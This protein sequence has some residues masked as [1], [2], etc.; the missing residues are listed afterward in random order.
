MLHRDYL[1]EQFVRF[2]EAIRLSWR[3]SKG[4]DADPLAAAELLE[5]A[6]GTATSI[7]GATLLML[8]PDSIAS[9]LQVTDTDPDVVEYVARTLLLE[10]AYLE[11]GGNDGLARLRREQAFAVAAGYGIPLSDESLSEAEFEEF[12]ERTEHRGA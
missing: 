2:A 3:R 8:S 9:I 7:D 11:Q 10:S 5:A 12:F 4:E 6:I 1:V